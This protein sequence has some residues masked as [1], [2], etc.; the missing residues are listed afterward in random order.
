VRLGIIGSRAF[1][2]PERFIH[3]ALDGLGVGDILMSGGARNVDEKAEFEAAERG[4]TVIS[5]RPRKA[6][7][8]F[9]VERLIDGKSAGLVGDPAV[10]FATFRDATFDRNWI[11]AREVERLTVCWD[12]QST[13]TA[14]GIACAVALGRPLVVHLPTE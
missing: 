6:S 3:L 13:G 1:P 5:L 14:H 12:G 4:L 8:R 7:S 9:Y 10:A 2:S 11:I